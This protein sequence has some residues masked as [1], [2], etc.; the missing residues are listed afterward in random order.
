MIVLHGGKTRV[1]AEVWDYGNGFR[2]WVWFVDSPVRAR[3][4]FF[5]WDY[6]IKYA[7]VDCTSKATP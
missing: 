2:R 1:Y 7:L 3:R 6:A 4:W 5:S